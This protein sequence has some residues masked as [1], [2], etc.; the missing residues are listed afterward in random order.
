MESFGWPILFGRGGF[1]GGESFADGPIRLEQVVEKGVI[2]V[3]ISKNAAQ[4]LK[5]LLSHFKWLTA[6]LK[7]CPFAQVRRGLIGP[8]FFAANE[9]HWSLQ[10]EIFR[11]V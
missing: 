5:L 3:G 6:R 10:R 1:W 2:S 7:S 8:S 11:V 9:A 4:W